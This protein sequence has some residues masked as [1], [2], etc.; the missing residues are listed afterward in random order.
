MSTKSKSTPMKRKALFQRRA[1]IC[2][3]LGFPIINFLVFYVYVNLD[4]FLMAFQRPL[5]GAGYNATRFTT[6]NFSRIKDLLSVS[7]D[8]ILIQALKNTLVMYVAGI[9]IGLPIS[10]LMSYFVYKKILGYKV[11]RSVTYLPNIITSS[12][13]VVLFKNQIGPGGVLN[14]VMDKM[15]MKYLDPITKAPSAFNTIL[16]YCLSFGFGVNMI[17]LNSAMLS[18]NDEMTEAAQ[19]DGCNWFQELIYIILPSIWPTVSTI[20]VLSTA[21]ILGTTGPILAFTKGTTGTMTLSFYIYQL[22]SGVG[23]GNND[24]YL[25]SAIGL[26]MTLVSFPI[27]LIV[28]RVVYGK[29]QD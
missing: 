16:F 1:F 23:T 15:G 8:G 6:E 11:F 21:G 7:N 14:M 2:C 19:I 17:L 22:V 3:F 26:L 25:A 12:A 5:L 13:L 10:I 24:L 20:I 9:I 4:S 18:V 29:E 27:T 28:R